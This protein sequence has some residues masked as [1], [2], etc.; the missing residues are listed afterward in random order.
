[1]ISVHAAAALAACVPLAQADRFGDI[2]F[3]ET[4]RSDDARFVSADCDEDG[5]TGRDRSGVEYRTN[6][7]WLLQKIMHGRGPSSAFEGGLS[8]EAP[9][10]RVLTAP[11]CMEDGG[12]WLTLDL[13]NP[14]RP[15]YGLYAQP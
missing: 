4:V 3:D 7:T 11:V 6:G 14:D 5:C 9:D 15:V 1:M 12:M 13:T 2:R 10:S 8:P